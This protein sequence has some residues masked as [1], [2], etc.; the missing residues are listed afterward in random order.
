MVKK[1]IINMVYLQKIIGILLDPLTLT[2]G[3]RYDKHEDFGDNV[4]PR[5]ICNLCYK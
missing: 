2:L 4:S 1:N 3:A 5:A